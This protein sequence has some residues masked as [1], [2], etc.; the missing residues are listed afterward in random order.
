MGRPSHHLIIPKRDAQAHLESST[1]EPSTV[2][3]YVPQT[4]EATKS[5]NLDTSHLHSARQFPKGAHRRDLIW[6]LQGPMA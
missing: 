1:P 3:V 2:A 6:L 5:V 4:T